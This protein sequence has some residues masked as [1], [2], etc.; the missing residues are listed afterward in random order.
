VLHGR[1]GPIDPVDPPERHERELADAQ[2]RLA[3]LGVAA[4]ESE[5]LIGDPGPAAVRFAARRG[6]DLIIVGAHEG[7]L[8]SRLLGGSVTDA[9]VHTAQ[10]DVLVVH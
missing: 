4:V 5:V 9:V 3:A 2:A 7:G 10:T 8:V 1:G 6:A